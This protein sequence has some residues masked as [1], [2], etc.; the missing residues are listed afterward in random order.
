MKKT[1]SKIKK[2]IQEMVAQEL[3]FLEKQIKIHSLTHLKQTMQ[4]ATA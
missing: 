1:M 3:Q 2:E 4:Q